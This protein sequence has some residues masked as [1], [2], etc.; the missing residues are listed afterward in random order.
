MSAQ[1]LLLDSADL[2]DVR[3]AAASGVVAGVTTNPSLLHAAAAGRDAVEHVAAIA[4]ALPAGPV[5]LQLHAR[6]DDAALEQA[7]RA[8]RA[9][10]DDAGRLVFKLPAQPRWY[11]LGARL[12]AQGHDV[13]MTAVYTPGQV[14]AAVQCGA[15]W[16]IPYVDRARRLRPESGDLVAALAAAAGGRVRVLAASVKSPEQAVAAVGSGADAVTASWPVL[17]ALMLDDLTDSAVAAFESEV[18]V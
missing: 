7:A 5:F 14:L 17:R 13:A 11:A 9:L 8:V 15:S 6:D 10:G 4:R 3:A 1:L 16:V 18:P 2:D 12:R